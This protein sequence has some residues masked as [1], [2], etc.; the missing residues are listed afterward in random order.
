MSLDV[1]TSR[2]TVMDA[3]RPVMEQLAAA[4]IRATLDIAQLNPPGVILLPPELD[5]RFNAGDFTASYALIAVVGS[6]DRTRM[7]VAL[8]DFL[9]SVLQA[10]GDRPVTARPVDVT[11]ADASTVLP[12]Y[13]LRWTT[14][15]R[16]R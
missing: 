8:S 16:H 14:R 5:F 3:I 11:L 12:G 10:L 4:G 2:P 6:S 7:I 1:A 13:E 15:I 9:P